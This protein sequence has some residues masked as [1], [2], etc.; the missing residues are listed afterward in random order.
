M[1]IFIRV[2]VYV[3][4][5]AD[6][7]LQDF[8]AGVLSKKRNF[9]LCTSVVYIIARNMHP[10]YNWIIIIKCSV[11]IENKIGP[12]RRTARPSPPLP[13]SACLRQFW[14]NS[15]R[16]TGI[17]SVYTRP[18]SP[19]TYSRL[20]VSVDGKGALAMVSC[21]CWVFWRQF[22]LIPRHN[23]A[24]GTGYSRTFFLKKGHVVNRHLAQLLTSGHVKDTL[25]RIWDCALLVG[26]TP[27]FFATPFR[28]LVPCWTW[29]SE[30]W[31]ASFGSQIC[32]LPP[33]WPWIWHWLCLG[34]SFSSVKWVWTASLYD[35]CCGKVHEGAL[36]GT[37]VWVPQTEVFTRLPLE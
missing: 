22:K 6:K 30:G 20:W 35:I 14:Q 2:C 4:V 12:S 37:V 32:P 13:A 9:I 29:H 16:M 8:M 7:C 11:D 34:L 33:L 31:R 10:F 21:R 28:I 3:F 24:P 1:C 27:L 15:S 19:V 25:H 18:W 17:Y 26:W 23:N 36:W 5:Y